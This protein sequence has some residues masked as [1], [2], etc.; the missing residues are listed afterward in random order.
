MA[1]LSEDSTAKKN[2]SF[3]SYSFLD[4]I[5]WYSSLFKPVS[6]VSGSSKF[7]SLTKIDSLEVHLKIN[8]NRIM[9]DIFCIFI[10][11]PP[12]NQLINSLSDLVRF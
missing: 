9:K 7:R 11:N 3:R 1:I 12:L 6:S 5:F 2:K 10:S 8:E 4:K